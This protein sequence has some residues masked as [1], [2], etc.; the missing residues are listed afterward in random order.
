MERWALTHFIRLANVKNWL[1][2][3]EH[4][5]CLHV[6]SDELDLQRPRI[7]SINKSDCLQIS[8]ARFDALA[9]AQITEGFS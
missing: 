2:F 3:D 9:T 7:W 6:Y 8:V 5:P 1:G 4:K